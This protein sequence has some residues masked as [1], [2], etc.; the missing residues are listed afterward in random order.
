[1]QK[2]RLRARGQSRVRVWSL[3]WAQEP[4][5]PVP[6]AQGALCLFLLSCDRFTQR[7]AARAAFGTE[8]RSAEGQAWSSTS[9]LQCSPGG[10]ACLPGPPDQ[11]SAGRLRGSATQFFILKERVVLNPSSTGGTVGASPTS[12]GSRGPSRFSKGCECEELVGCVHETPSRFGRGSGPF[13][14]WCQLAGVR[15]PT[16]VSKIPSIWDIPVE[17]T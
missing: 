8:G 11:G 7:S 12:P 2:P 3:P 5:P 15:R 13:G 1:M 17:T 16:A 4:P 9:A 10:T 6:R 14:R